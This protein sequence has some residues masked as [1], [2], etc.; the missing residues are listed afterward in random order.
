MQTLPVPCPAAAPLPPFSCRFP[1]DDTRNPSRLLA[2]PR[3]FPH[4][5]PQFPLRTHA[6]SRFRTLICAATP[7]ERALPSS[8]NSATEPRCSARQVDARDNKR[9]QLS[10]TAI[11]ARE[12]GAHEPLTLYYLVF[13]FAVC[14]I[15]GLILETVVSYFVDGR[16]ESRVGFVWGPFSPI[17]GVGGVLI[18]LALHRFKNAS[19]LVI[20]AVSAAFG[21]AFEYFAAWFW[22]SAFGIVAWSYIDQPFNIGG[23]TCLG[24]ALVWG[25]AGLAWVKLAAPMLKE[26]SEAVPRAWREPL[27]WALL[28]F[29]LADAATTMLALDC[30]MNRLNGLEPEGALQQFFAQHYGDG[31]MQAKFETMSMYPQLATLRG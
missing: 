24:I 23:K 9:M 1:A 29:F 3:H 16:W 2:Q 27:A 13:V 30:W 5:L 22:E 17:Y 21:A 26:A 15:L 19:P 28:I 31:A 6:I 4:K 20:Y 18:T 12:K 7:R 11:P 10:T 25:L 8:S 14:S